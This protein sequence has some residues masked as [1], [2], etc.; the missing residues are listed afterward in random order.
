M[1]GVFLFDFELA[2]RMRTKTRTSSKG[3]S[4]HLLSPFLTEVG[5]L[6]R[7]QV[8]FDVY[9]GCWWY[10]WLPAYTLDPRLWV[11]SPL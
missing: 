4:G 3:G 9:L 11:D 8:R 1:W 6:D 2:G 7:G 5:W 10:G